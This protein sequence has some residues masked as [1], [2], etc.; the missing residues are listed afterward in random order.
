MLKKKTL[1]RQDVEYIVLQIR[2]QIS[3][4]SRSLGTLMQ[5][6]LFDVYVWLK[7]TL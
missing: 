7:A 4:T 3:H 6:C 2:I 5:R 1:K